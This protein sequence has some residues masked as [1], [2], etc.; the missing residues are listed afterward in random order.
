[1]VYPVLIPL[2]GVIIVHQVRVL[3]VFAERVDDEES[4]NEVEFFPWCGSS[5]YDAVNYLSESKK[6]ER[7]MA[8]G[9][10]DSLLF[11]TRV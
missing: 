6:V 9:L 2:D 11:S 3:C 5:A 8:G 1:M 4:S 10:N 7:R